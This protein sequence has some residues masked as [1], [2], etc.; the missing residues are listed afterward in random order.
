MEFRWPHKHP[1]RF[2]AICAKTAPGVV[3]LADHVD[4]IDSLPAG[5]YFLGV[6]TNGERVTWNSN[7]EDPHFAVNGL[8]RRGKTNLNLGLTSQALRRREQVVAIDHKR[9][10]LRC[11]AGIPGFTLRNNPADV[12]GMWEA[13]H[14]FR[15]AMDEAI[16]EHERNPLLPLSHRLLIIEEIN[17]LWA[18]FRSHW[19]LKKEPGQ[20]ITD[21][22]AW[23]D[24]K[25]ILHQGGQFGWRV[26][27]DGQ[28]L[29]A[30]VLFGS[31]YSFGNV[32]L[33][34]WKAQQW[35]YCVGTTP[36]PPAPKKKGRMCLAQG[37]GH[38]WVQV[39]IAD[40]RGDHHNEQAWREF[41]LNGRHTRQD[42]T[43]AGQQRSGA[44]GWRAVLPPVPD[45]A[46]PALSPVLIGPKQAAAYLGMTQDQF[47]MARRRYPIQGEF[48]HMTRGQETSCWAKETLD[49]WVAEVRQDA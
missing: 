6:D 20:R 28:D 42:T 13:I 30:E 41:A 32:G 46:V 16:T 24:V 33:F 49:L 44:W 27:I 26:I 1:M 21:V 4:F 19:E 31:R 34:G 36:V 7:E 37:P 12:A 39:V 14:D 11:L 8:S 48:K 18:M 40:P 9:V 10:S 43:W 29:K 15:L 17:E 47:K 22:P 38:R 3:A 5:V 23:R 35:R 45:H 25:A 2:E